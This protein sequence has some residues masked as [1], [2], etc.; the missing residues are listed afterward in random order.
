[1]NLQYS[2]KAESIIYYLGWRRRTP[3]THFEWVKAR[4]NHI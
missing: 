4:G 2:L 1:M 3:K